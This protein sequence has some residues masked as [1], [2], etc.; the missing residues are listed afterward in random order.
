MDLEIMTSQANH[1]ELSTFFEKFGCVSSCEILRERKRPHGS[2]GIGFITF[3]EETTADRVLSASEDDLC[4]RMRVLQLEPA[5]QKIKVAQM[6]KGAAIRSPQEEQRRE[7]EGSL[8]HLHELPEE[9]LI[10]IFTFLP[11]RCVLQ[12][13]RGL[14]DSL[15]LAL[16]KKCGPNL[17]SLNLDISLK[18]CPGVGED[19]LWWLFKECDRLKAISL[20]GNKRLTGKCFHVLRGGAESLVLS[21]CIQLRDVGL[22]KISLRCKQMLKKIDLSHCYTI[23]DTG[24]NI[25]IEHCKLL[26]VVGL[27]ALSPV[28]VSSSCLRNLGTLPNL[29]ELYLR[30]NAMVDDQVVKAISEGCA[31]LR[32][33]DLQ[34]CNRSVTDLSMESL[35][36]LQHLQELTIS[37]LHLV[38]DS[39]L[40]LL[41]SIQTLRK[42][43]ARGCGGI[44]NEGVRA[45]T[46][47]CAE[48]QF[49]DISGCLQLNESILTQDTLLKR[50]QRD[51]HLTLVIGGTGVQ[52]SVFQP[53]PSFLTFDA[54]D[55]S[56]HN[57][58][59]D[60]QTESL[61]FLSSDSEDEFEVVGDY[62]DFLAADDPLQAEEFEMS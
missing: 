33:L 10:H 35:S 24:L 15:V 9:I 30:D 57:L 58:I 14:D 59:L 51:L 44:T 4:F 28:S 22:E 38:H 27:E 45:I 8:L 21:N 1:K 34:C 17:R 50:G 47:D 23:S 3:Q 55:L 56:R 48:L 29:Q 6:A 53:L 61:E 49:L 20:D 12:N 42:L 25:L 52:T 19:G 37:Y 11:L 36:W 26:E 32:I 39:G 43:V 60:H 13:A 16:L 46:K 2:Q 7:V 41:S 31:Q 40:C 54:M 5:K 62:D 18:L